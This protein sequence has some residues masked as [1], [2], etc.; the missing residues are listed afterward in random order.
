MFPLEEEE[1]EELIVKRDDD[2]VKLAKALSSV[3]RI[4]ILR[5][6]DND[7]VDVSQIA[8]AQ[9]QTGANISAQIK[10]LEKAQLVLSQYQPGK[11]GV[12]KVC[13][14]GVKRIIIELEE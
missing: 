7:G 2:I 10:I 5:M 14:P 4:K 3:T 8:E 11:H 6:L 13:K 12:R 9:D 1:E